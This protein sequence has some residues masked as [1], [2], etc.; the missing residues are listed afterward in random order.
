MLHSCGDC[1]LQLSVDGIN[2]ALR[3]RRQDWLAR[4]LRDV[5]CKRKW[6]P[7][8]VLLF[9]FLRQ[10]KVPHL[11]SACIFLS[12]VQLRLIWISFRRQNHFPGCLVCHHIWVVCCLLEICFSS[13]SLSWIPCFEI[14]RFVVSSIWFLS[15][16]LLVIYPF[17]FNLQIPFCHQPAVICFHW[18]HGSDISPYFFSKEEKWVSDQMLN[19]SSI[20][21]Q[22]EDLG[23]WHGHSLPAFGGP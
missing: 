3:E 13:C 9:A 22:M 10:G 16:A 18:H 15:P 21:L 12:C 1:Q 19:T 2:G 17:A 14:S 7:L 11:D 5:T 8:N 23:L 20:Y 6:N 4:E